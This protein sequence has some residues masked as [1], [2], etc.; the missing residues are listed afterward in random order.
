[1]INTNLGNLGPEVNLCRTLSISTKP[2][3]QLPL[4]QGLCPSG[5]LLHWSPT[6]CTRSL[7]RERQVWT[8]GT[9]PWA[10]ESCTALGPALAPCP[11]SEVTNF[12]QEFPHFTQ[13][14]LCL[15]KYTY[16]CVEPLSQIHKWHQSPHVFPVSNEMQTR[17]TSATSTEAVKA[18]M[19]LSPKLFL[20]PRKQQHPR[21]SHSVDSI[22]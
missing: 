17:V 9:Q 4:L 5:L 22:P 19:Q 3:V 13:Q 8:F 21:K 15:G 18:T 1:M 10:P 6:S 12:S 2:T 16:R 11:S 14:V 7:A 20:P